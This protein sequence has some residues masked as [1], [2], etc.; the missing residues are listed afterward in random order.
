MKR[1][2][3]GKLRK[4][5]LEMTFWY[6][7]L[8]LSGISS[9]KYNTQLEP[10]KGCTLVEIGCGTGANF[11]FLE[12]A[13]GEEGRIVG[14]DL[15]IEMLREAERRVRNREWKNLALVN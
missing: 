3:L 10:S 9:E 14:V 7:L 1:A 4:S 8:G 2:S 11:Q 12:E 15:S 6:N 13:V 5:D